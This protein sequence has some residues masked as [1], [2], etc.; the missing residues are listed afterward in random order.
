MECDDSCTGTIATQTYEN[1][2]ITLLI[3][4]P[5]FGST[6]STSGGTTYAGLASSEGGNGQLMA[7]QFPA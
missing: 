2:T 7:S 3:A 6:L 5:I 4:D 1:T